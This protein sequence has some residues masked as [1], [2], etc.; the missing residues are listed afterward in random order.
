MKKKIYVCS[1]CKGDIKNNVE[2]AR[3]YSKY[4]AR[5]GFIPFTPHLYFTDF[6]DDS[7]PEERKIGL[8]LAL[9]WLFQCD[10]LWYF[11]EII[12]DGMKNEIEIAKKLGI[13]I[14]KIP[15]EFVKIFLK[16]W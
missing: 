9:E 10:E 8:R 11:G 2:K 4:V 15:T 16:K 13:K 5:K 6:L 1:P 14:V 12:S 7:K 3:L